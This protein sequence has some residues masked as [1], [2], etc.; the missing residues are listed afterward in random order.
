MK[1]ILEHFLEAIDVRYNKHFADALYNEHPHRYNMYGLKKMLDVYGVKT[2]GVQIESKD[3]SNLNYPCILHTHGDFV[4]GVDC[5]TDKITYLQDGKRKIISHDVFKQTWTGNALVIEEITEAEEPDYKIH[6]RE[7]IL[8]MAKTYCIPAILVFSS[9]IGILSHIEDMRTLSIISILLYIMGVLVCSMLIQKQLFGESRYGDKICGLFNHADCNSILNGSKSKILGISWSE[10]GMGYFMAS[11]LLMSLYPK[12]IGTV[13]IINWIAM[14][15]G[16]W[17]IYYQWRIAK[18]WC[19]L[20]VTSQI[21]IWL[22]GIVAIISCISTPFTYNFACSMLTCMMYAANI[23]CIHHY[24]KAHVLEK[25]RIRAVQ[26]YRAL[27]SN[28]I[29]LNTLIKKGKYYETSIE[30]S[31]II[32]GNPTAKMRVTVFSNPHCNPCA[33]M[34]N[35]MDKLLDSCGDRICVQYIFS[36]FS[37]QF[38]DSCRYLISCF[39]ENN[40]KEAR[41]L[42]SLW[43]NKDK[44]NY[45]RIT[46]EKISNNNV[47]T[48]ED[49]LKRHHVWQKRTGL[50]ATPTILINNYELPKEY[51]PNDLTMIMDLMIE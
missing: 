49:E 19:I 37:E 23:V 50:V 41:N 48:V 28:S 16:I 2:L 21:I 47:F 17:S 36:S 12:S 32:F 42:F 6:H 51:E 20:C 13:A 38:E 33:A 5:G 43:Y 46:K 26:Q 34:H 22:I 27:K 40:Q 15:Y 10:V 35:E 18:S 44:N 9:I 45:K 14:I 1:N 4:I 24:T 29:V 3:L 8:M 11:I 31:S 30:D 25:E 7:E 39:K